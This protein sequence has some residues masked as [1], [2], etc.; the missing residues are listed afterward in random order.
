M[1]KLYASALI[2]C[3]SS[4]AAE[5]LARKLSNKWS[6]FRDLRAS[7]NRLTVISGPHVARYAK[8][9]PETCNITELFSVSVSQ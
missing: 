7:G 4:Y 9:Q 8:K 2:L 5:R 3:H 1:K 6:K